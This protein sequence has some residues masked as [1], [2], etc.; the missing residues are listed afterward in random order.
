MKP[1]FV[2]KLTEDKAEVLE[3]IPLNKEHNGKTMVK[4][5]KT[6]FIYYE[7]IENIASTRENALEILQ[8][9][10]SNLTNQIKELWSRK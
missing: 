2:A 10:V 1:M 5:L 3:V 9:R 7:K 8:S 6:G 4:V